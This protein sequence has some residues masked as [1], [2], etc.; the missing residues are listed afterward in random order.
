[1][2]TPATNVLLYNAALNGYVAGALAGAYQT[3]PTQADYTAIVNQANTFADA[4][5]TA[6]P[7]DTNISNVPGPGPGT[8]LVPSNQ[9]ITAYQAQRVQLLEMLCFGFAFQRYTT[10][11]AAANFATAIAAIRAVYLQTLTVARV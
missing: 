7:N 2:S 4:V 3:D 6:F 5:D 9:A 8:A 10:G 11:V 1:M